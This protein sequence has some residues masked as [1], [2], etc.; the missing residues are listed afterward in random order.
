MLQ[1]CNSKRFSNVIFLTFLLP[2]ALAFAVRKIRRIRRNRYE[3]TAM[4]GHELAMAL[5]LAYLT[6]HRRTDAVLAKHGVTADQFVSIN[7]VVAK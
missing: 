1:N 7:G 5:R 4:S 3:E 2:V 6:M